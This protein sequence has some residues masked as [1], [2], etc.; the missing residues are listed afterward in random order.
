M[1][2]DPEGVFH[3]FLRCMEWWSM[4]QERLLLYML[5]TS[6][7]SVWA[8]ENR[9][10]SYW[11]DPTLYLCMSTWISGVSGHAGLMDW[12]CCDDI[13]FRRLTR[14]SIQASKHFKLQ[15]THRVGSV[16]YLYVHVVTWYALQMQP[17]YFW[18]RDKQPDVTRT[19]QIL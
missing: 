15:Y 10:C 7:Y 4:W 3:C 12:A 1:F 9:W 18:A 2:I 17:W 16:F 14:L 8:P 19:L 6:W 11:N 5:Y 13:Q